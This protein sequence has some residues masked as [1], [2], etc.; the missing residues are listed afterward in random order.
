MYLCVV[1][2][3][4]CQLVPSAERDPALP[5]LGQVSG[6]KIDAVPSHGLTCVVPS[7][8]RTICIRFV[9]E[10]MCVKNCAASYFEVP[11]E[12]D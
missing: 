7:P 6:A 12:A 3:C 9:F 11:F 5:P 1:V 8:A 4:G 2:K 10:A